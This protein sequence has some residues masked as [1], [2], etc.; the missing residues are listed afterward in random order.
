MDLRK[1]LLLNA[2][3]GTIVVGVIL[4][5]LWAYSADQ[6]RALGGQAV[7]ASPEDGMRALI[8]SN[9]SGVKKVE[10]VHA[11]SEI[12]DDLW[13]VEAHVWAA[14]RIDGK[15]FSDQDFDKPASFFLRMHNGWT[16]VPEGKFPEV[17]ALG[18]WLFHPSQ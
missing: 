10:I 5:T 1:K 4:T 15:G 13:F 7:H 11:G 6:L 14:S 16:F 17:I 9:Y 8:A 12:I 2:A 18:K 3:I